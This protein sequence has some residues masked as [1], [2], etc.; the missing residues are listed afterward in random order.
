MIISRIITL[1]ILLIFLCETFDQNFITF[2][3][4]ANQTSIAKN[5]CENHDKPQ[6]HCNGK[7]QLQKKLNQQN[8]K[9]PERKTE[10]RNETLSSKS[11]FASVEP[12][13]LIPFKKRYFSKHTDQPQDQ[14]SSFFHPPQSLFM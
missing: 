6:M 13:I 8:N 12:V 14:S 10:S 4:Y 5:L 2:V 3:F 1:F 9:T 7:C 11:F